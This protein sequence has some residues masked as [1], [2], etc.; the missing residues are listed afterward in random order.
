MATTPD[1]SYLFVVDAGRGLVAAMHTETLKVRTAPLDLPFTGAIGRTSARISPDGQ[2]L[3]VAIAG[4]DTSAATAGDDGSL[5]TALDASTFEVLDTW[6]LDESVTGLGVSTDGDSLYVA[7]ELGISV[8]DT[9]TGDELVTV[10]I[11]GS[12]RITQ[13][14]PLAG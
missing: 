11:A 12:Y 3:F 13:V 7:S 4:D 9:S 2:T 6:R 10:P 14:T 8:L 5:V 1:G